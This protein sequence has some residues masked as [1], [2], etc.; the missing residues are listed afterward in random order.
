M[1]REPRPNAS[2]RLAEW[3]NRHSDAVLQRFYQVTRHPVQHRLE[4]LPTTSHGVLVAATQLLNDEM[5]RLHF[6]GDGLEDRPQ[7]RED[8]EH[9]MGPPIQQLGRRRRAAHDR[10]QPIQFVRY[11]TRFGV[12]RLG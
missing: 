7:V 9:R 4:V 8:F 5:R 11:C 12:V 6:D 1:T 3:G 10:R 2:N